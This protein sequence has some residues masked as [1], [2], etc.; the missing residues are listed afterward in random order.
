M[1][2]DQRPSADLERVQEAYLALSEAVVGPLGSTCIRAEKM[3]DEEWLRRQWANAV[4][5]WRWWKKEAERLGGEQ[6]TTLVMRAKNWESRARHAEALLASL[7]INPHPLP[8]E[9]EVR[10]LGLRDG[11][12]VKPD[13]QADG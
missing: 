12:V 1:A 13:G 4:D 11:I 5:Q 10:R 8:T 7:G 6:P 9:D 2:D 3:A